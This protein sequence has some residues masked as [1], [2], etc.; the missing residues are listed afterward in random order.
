MN[1]R[2]LC[3]VLTGLLLCFFAR[4]DAQS[5]TDALPQAFAHP[6][7]DAR[8]MMRWCWFAPAVT[9]TELL[10]E[11]EEMK[12]A[13]MRGV[14]VAALYPQSLDIDATG[15]HTASYL[16]DEYIDDLRFAPHEATRLGLRMD[17]TLGSG[18][19][20]G[21]PAIPVTQAAGMLRVERV[22]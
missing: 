12:A 10:R 7:D 3:L 21:G 4:A 8:V 22:P 14:E 13:G 5:S 19:P 9:R 15:L 17:L 18:W 11:L 20:F 16:S 2:R 1:P 6:P